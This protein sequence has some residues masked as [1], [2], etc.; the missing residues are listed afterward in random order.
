MNKADP[1]SNHEEILM[2][3]H[4]VFR[5][6]QLNLNRYIDAEV[7]KNSVRIVG[8]WCNY[9]NKKL[10]EK[11][12]FIK[13]LETEKRNLQ[14]EVANCKSKIENQRKQINEQANAL[15]KKS[16]RIRTLN[17][18][19]VARDTMITSQND[20]I[21]DQGQALKSFEK[22]TS[23]LKSKLAEAKKQ[24]DHYI[25]EI[26][27]VSNL[28]IDMMRESDREYEEK[29]SDQG[30]MKDYYYSAF[31]SEMKAHDLLKDTCQK[32]A[33]VH[34]TQLYDKAKEIEVLKKIWR[35]LYPILNNSRRSLN[36]H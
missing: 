17:G 27:R 36:Y 28:S 5:E 19:V 31:L 22:T 6:L 4:Q 29:L 11:D 24:N 1:F 9:V 2:V 23:D 3:H 16:S 7:S 25:S 20:Q 33:A 35:Q 30:K 32:Q 26:C 8:E 14:A 18:D 13:Q 12:A 15:S 34:K 10:S 21:L